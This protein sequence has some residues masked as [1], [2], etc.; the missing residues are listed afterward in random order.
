MPQCRVVRPEMVR[1]QLS[2]GDFIDVKKELNAGEYFDLLTD[3]SA[4][5]PYAKA[6]AYLIGWSLVGAE[7]APLPYS[8]EMDEQARRDTVRALSV[9]TMREIIAVIDKHEA[10]EE[11]QHTKKKETPAVSPASNPT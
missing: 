11:R 8:L 1:L 9:R 7:S 2:D 5:K 10:S 4:R 3:L 6:L